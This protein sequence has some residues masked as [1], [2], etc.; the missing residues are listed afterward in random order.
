MKAPELAEVLM[1]EKDYLS[2]VIKGVEPGLRVNS[3]PSVTFSVTKNSSRAV[4][5][6]SRGLHDAFLVRNHAH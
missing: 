5:A 2:A 4:L 1:L 6:N 3:D